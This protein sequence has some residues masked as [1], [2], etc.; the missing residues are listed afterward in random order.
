MYLN[1]LPKQDVFMEWEFGNFD[2]SIVFRRQNCVGMQVFMIF[3]Y[4]YMDL[5]ILESEIYMLC[6]LPSGNSVVLKGLSLG[7]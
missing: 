4:L 2:D 5:E 6:N 7:K 3:G 1:F